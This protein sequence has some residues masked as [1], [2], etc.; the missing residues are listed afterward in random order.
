MERAIA[1]ERTRNEDIKEQRANPTT[2]E[3]YDEASDRM[4]SYTHLEGGGVKGL[5]RGFRWE[6]VIAT[7]DM[8]PESHIELACGCYDG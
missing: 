8:F 5:G 3:Y 7:D 1:M 4:L 2:R 6:D